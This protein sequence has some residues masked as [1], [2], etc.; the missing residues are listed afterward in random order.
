MCVCVCVCV[1]VCGE[2]AG[3]RERGC[4]ESKRERLIY[5]KELAHM[6]VGDGKS[7]ICKAS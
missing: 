1:C 7:E 2:R 5:F 3:G 6:I 4:S